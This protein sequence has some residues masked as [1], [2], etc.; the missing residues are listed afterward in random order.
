MRRHLPIGAL[1]AGLLLC[2]ATGCGYRLLRADALLGQDAVVVVPFGE[3]TPLGL[4]TPLA[5]AL[6]DQAASSGLR[7]ATDPATAP[8]KLTGTVLSSSTTASQTRSASATVRAYA[9]AVIVEAELVE[10][11][12][13]VRFRD[14]F[15]FR[16]DFLASTT[17]T[18]ESNLETEANRRR[19][20]TLIAERAG[21][22]IWNAVLATAAASVPTEP[23]GADARP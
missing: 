12:G 8:L 13:T 14:R 15:R 19:A 9:V 18:A 16:E 17:A 22:D 7:L 4:S 11:D 20:L 6:R 2:A 3:Q 5:D 10:K 1:V 21:R 23:G